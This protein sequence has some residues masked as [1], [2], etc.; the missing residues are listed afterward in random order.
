MPVPDISVVILN[1]RQ[2]G[3][4]RQC[5]RGVLLSKPRCSYEVI[6]VDNH[7]HDRCLEM[8]AEQFPWAVRLQSPVNGGFSAGNNLGIRTARGRYILILNPDI[9]LLEGQ[10]D[11]LLEFC[12]SHPR[13]GVVGPRLTYP[14]GAPQESC[15][16]FPQLFIPLYRRT[17][18]GRLPS[19]QRK[20]DA[21]LMRDFNHAECRP[22]D[23]LM[24]ACLLVRRETFDAVGL[25]DEKYFLYYEDLDFC[26]RCWDAHWEVWYVAHVAPVH[27]HQRLSAHGGRL[28]AVVANRAAWHHLRSALRYYGKYARKSF[29]V[30]SPSGQEAARSVE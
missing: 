1:Y 22:V 29:P 6:V 10:L 13:V 11:A 25:F 4:V 21:F 5:L 19:V 20:L 17:L 8:V 26:R 12:E 24:G 28:T 9:A 14:L 23:W 16:R 30:S 7:S 2:R 3:L 15:R 18:L 27:Y